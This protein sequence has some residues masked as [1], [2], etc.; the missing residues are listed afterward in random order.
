MVHG[1]G[2]SPVLVDELAALEP[3][4]QVSLIAFNDNLFTLARRSTDPAARLR[5]VDRLAAWARA[6]GNVRDRV[7][8]L[9]VYLGHARPENTYWY[10]TS[11][12]QVLHPAGEQ[13]E[14]YVTNG[15]VAP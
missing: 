3:D 5:A 7:P 13:F 2:L 4:D 12:P 8:A 14:T 11:S 9:A 15:S 10:L 1:Y 6:G